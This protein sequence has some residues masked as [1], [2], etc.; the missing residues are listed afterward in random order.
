MSGVI[1]VASFHPRY[2]FA[3]TAPD[4]VENLSNRSPHPMLHL[5]REASIDQAVA[6][7]PEAASIYERNVETLRRLGFDGWRRLMSGSGPA[8]TRA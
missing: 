3:G 7:F 4:D 8:S 6:A 2:Q 1:Q 5:L